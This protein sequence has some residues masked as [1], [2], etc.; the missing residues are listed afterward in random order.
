MTNISHSSPAPWSSD[1]MDTILPQ[2]INKALCGAQE[3]SYIVPTD[4]ISS[5]LICLSEVN[6]RQATLR[7]KSCDS[8]NPVYLL[9]VAWKNPLNPVNAKRQSILDFKS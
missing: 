9:V 1:Q 7:Q 4:F 2:I 8:C 3:E 5:F 6:D